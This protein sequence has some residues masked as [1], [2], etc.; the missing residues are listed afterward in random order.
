MKKILVTGGMGF[1]GSTLIR[2]LLLNNYIVLNIDMLTYASTKETLKDIEN[3]KNYLFANVDIRN[4]SKLYNLFKKFCPNKVIHLAAESHVD[5]SIDSP[6]IF[7]ET[8]VIGTF[9]LLDVASKYWNK[10]DNFKNFRF[11]H[12]ST[13]EVYGDLLDSKNLFTEKTS[14][15]PSSPY[16]ASKASSDHLVRAWHR[17]YNFPSIITNCSN[18]YGPYQF[19][20]KFIP[21]MILSAL[22]GKKLP[23]YGNGLQVRDWLNVNDHAKALIKVLRKGKVG[24]TYNIGGLNEKTNIYVVKTICKFLEELAPDK[25]KG[26]KNYADLITL[27]KDRPGHDTR[28]AIDSSKII[29]ELDWKPIESF[30]SG[31]YK[32]VK[33]YLENQKWWKK[34]LLRSYNLKRIGLKGKK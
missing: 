10:N 22:H 11:H 31:L 25:P 5:K 1:I 26:L 18:N 12:V 23:V 3:N 7:F 29:R 6:K 9:N 2:E 17:T 27:V 20:E 15:R 32:T 13:D 19:P 8:N 21:H 30:E 24:E 14:Y 4:Q 28:Y 16:A 34:I 33:W